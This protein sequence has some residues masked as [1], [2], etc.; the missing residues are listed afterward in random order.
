M[1]PV[2]LLFRYRNYMIFS[3][4]KQTIRL[5]AIHLKICKL[6]IIPNSFSFDC[7]KQHILPS[8]L[9]SNNVVFILSNK[10]T[11]FHDNVLWLIETEE[12][13]K[14]LIAWLTC[15]SYIYARL[16]FICRRTMDVRVCDTNVTTRFK[17]L[18]KVIQIQLTES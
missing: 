17:Q 14:R 7:M 15:V 4:K 9:N 3:W 5:K 8:G 2:C 1:I 18:F 12:E 11:C 10:F 13:C 16:T 6:Y